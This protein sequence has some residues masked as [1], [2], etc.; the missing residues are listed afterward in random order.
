M[1]YKVS[2]ALQEPMTITIL[3]SD[4]ISQ[5]TQSFSAGAWEIDNLICP[6]GTIIGFTE[7]DTFKGFGNV[8]FIEYDTRPTV[9]WTETFLPEL[10][11]SRWIYYSTNPSYIYNNKLR[12]V[13]NSSTTHC[14]IESKFLISGDFDVEL[15]F[16]LILAPAVAEWQFYLRVFFPCAGETISDDTSIQVRRCYNTSNKYYF[17]GYN[18]TPIATNVSVSDTSGKVRLVRSGSVITGY[19]WNGSSWTSIA[20][21]DFGTNFSGYPVKFIIGQNSL[22]GLPSAVIDCTN[23]KVNSGTI[24]YRFDDRFNYN[25]SS[26]IYSN[27]HTPNM[28]VYKPIS[29][30]PLI[31]YIVYNKLRF[32]LDY[33]QQAKGLELKEKLIGNFDVRVEIDIMA[34]PAADNWQFKMFAHYDGD[35]SIRIGRSYTASNTHCIRTETTVGGVANSYYVAFTSI[36]P[37]FRIRRIGTTVYT[38]YKDRTASTWTLHR[39]TNSFPTGEVTLR[40]YGSIAGTMIYGNATADFDN[41]IINNSD[42]INTKLLVD[43]PS[44]APTTTPEPNTALLLHFDESTLIDSSYNKYPLT[45]NSSVARSATQSKFGGYSGSFNGSTQYISLPS[46]ADWNFGSGDFTIDGWFYSLSQTGNPITLFSCGTPTN[47]INVY[48]KLDT[49]MYFQYYTG[50][51]WYGQATSTTFPIN[52]WH[53]VALVRFGTSLKLYYDGT[54]IGTLTL[55]GGFSFSHSNIKLADNGDG[56]PKFNGYMDEFRV[57]K[58]IARWTS[59]FTPPTSAYSA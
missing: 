26:T 57:S 17:E 21:T 58:G 54:L 41:L 4:G 32:E 27:Y 30:V 59:D 46:S 37:T 7:D 43:V 5:E 25:N 49:T 35:N 11:N 13:T 28:D 12:M 34:A 14:N 23:F 40:L 50:S 44:I 6:S 24:Q 38:Y 20:N 42:N 10:D 52:S 22:T 39:A 19:Y 1:A 36:S 2:G 33:T 51:T 15:S 16:D 18:G 31:P 56:V 53:H 9:P 48:S 29:S 47:H 3:N 8:P 55:P 45:L